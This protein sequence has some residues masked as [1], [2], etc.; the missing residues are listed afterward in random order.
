MTLSEE[1][2][3]IRDA[4]LTK[5]EKI[6]RLM[7][8]PGLTE[9]HSWLTYSSWVDEGM[10]EYEL[11]RGR[12]NAKKDFYYT[13]G[14]EME[15]YVHYRDVIKSA[16]GVKF[17]YEDYNHKCYDDHFKLVLDV[18]VDI[19]KEGVECVSPIL[20][21]E[22]GMAKLQK[23]CKA[24]NDNGAKVDR[25]CGMHIHIGVPGMGSKQFVNVF[26]NYQRCEEAID[27]FMPKSRRNNAYCCSLKEI[28]MEHCS[29]HNRLLELLTEGPARGTR[30]YKVNAESWEKYKTIEFR[31]HQGTTDF[32]KISNWIRFCVA[33][34]RYS[35]GQKVLDHDIQRVEDLPFLRDE[36]KSYYI[37]RREQIAKRTKKKDDGKE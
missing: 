16:K 36:Q 28:D 13:F 15:C 32:T 9:A 5:E 14:C 2:A 22:E 17:V 6:R 3:E 10:P 37:K 34:I 31:Q 33:L 8:L 30:Y 7:L 24:L 29:S 27:S 4:V 19:S 12:R 21:G 11:S 35:M 1:L 18:S 23:A 25:L 20:H 26:R